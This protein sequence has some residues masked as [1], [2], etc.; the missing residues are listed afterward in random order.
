MKFLIMEYYPS[1][2]T[3]PNITTLFSDNLILWS[4][5]QNNR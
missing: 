3:D 2:F 5:I 1:S 4:P